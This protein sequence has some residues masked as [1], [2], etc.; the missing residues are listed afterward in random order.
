VV[1]GIA[2][3]GRWGRA[4]ATHAFESIELCEALGSG[5]AGRAG[6]D[7]DELSVGVETSDLAGASPHGL[8]G[9]TATSLR[10]RVMLTRSYCT[11]RYVHGLR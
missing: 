10:L 3:Q 6:V 1:S 11:E 4:G 2:E 9:S 8:P 7:L 5:A